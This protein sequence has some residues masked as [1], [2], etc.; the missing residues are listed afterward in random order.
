MNLSL[1]QLYTVLSATIPQELD[2][3][4]RNRFVVTTYDNSYSVI[5]KLGPRS[6]FTTNVDDL[7]ERI[8]FNSK[9]FYLNDVYAEGAS[10]NSRSSVEL[11]QLHGSVR[12]RDRALT[13]GSL[14]IAT[15]AGRDPDRWNFLRQNLMSF[16]TL[17]WGYSMND[18]GTL[19]SLRSTLPG[20]QSISEGWIQIRPQS[21]ESAMTDFY[22]ALGLQLIVADTHEL[23][24]YLEDNVTPEAPT[25]AIDVSLENL[26]ASVNVPM[27]PTEDFFMGASP[28]WS[29]IYGNSV[30]K[31]SHYRTVANRISAGVNTVITGI[32]ASGK[33]TL[34]MQLAA[35]APFSGPRLMFDGLGEAEA[36]LLARRIGTRSA[37][38]ALDNVASD[39][40]ALAV[41]SKLPNIVVIAADRDYTLSS[42]SNLITKTKTEIVSITA[43]TKRDI[44]QIWQT[45]PLR[46]RVSKLR[47]PDT[48]P[49]VEPSIFEFIRTNV[50]GQGLE[51]RLIQYVQDMLDEDIDQAEVLILACYL[52]YARVPLSMDVTLAYF[53]GSI[54]DYK[55]VYEMM[56][57][58]GDLMHEYEGDLQLDNQDYFAARS[59]MIS[60]L[61]LYGVPSSALRS[62]LQRFHTNVSPLRINSFSAFKRRGFESRIFSKAFPSF[63][64]G[65]ALYDAIIEKQDVNTVPY[66]AQHKALFLADKKQYDLA[67]AEIDTARGSR[68][69]KVN[70]TIDNS[71]NKIL[72][73]A[74]VD[75][76]FI[77]PEALEL[78]LRALQGLKTAFDSDSR[79]G[80]HALVYADCAIRLSRVIV[81]DEALERLHMA[82]EMLSSV[83]TAESWLERPKFARSDVVR[84]INE[85]S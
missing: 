79:K 41:L 10:L 71:Y 49:G 55:R 56:S 85:L 61:V 26:P 57:A 39:A 65:T 74:N 52:H 38:V 20:Q 50:T 2:Q 42:V 69:G 7:F 11:I 66:I 34:L 28:S 32:P 31:T 15:A 63:K 22:R 24:L 16:P 62:V 30:T 44:Q 3:F 21:A 9:S 70:W 46:I 53:R 81:D 47:L 59:M 78:C 4:V 19:Q 18:T 23:L 67:F 1:P 25:A 36:K 80:A 8:F 48:S 84:R 43:L 5:E 72:F 6:I 37:L 27:R 76:V 75:K 68:R 13:F 73:M 35:Q 83:M 58:V 17:Y 64:D 14:D 45:I 33:T 12:A 54:S 82:R 77:D 40:G 51:E 29:D 60:E